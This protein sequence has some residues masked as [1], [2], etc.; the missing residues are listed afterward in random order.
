MK[1]TIH[2]ITFRDALKSACEVAPSKG[3]LP[4]QSCLYLRVQDD[5][6][7][8]CARDEST[9]IELVIPCQA[10][11]DGE[12]LVPSR[13]LLDYVSLADGSVTVSVDA[14]QRM[15]LKSGKKTSALACMDTDRFKP[16]AF[17]GEPVFTIDGAALSACIS[18]T[19]FA[20][21]TDE[22]RAVLCGIHLTIDPN[23]SAHFASCNGVEIAQC[24]MDKLDFNADWSEPRGIT[25]PNTALKLIQS[26]FGSYDHVTLSLETYRAAF[27]AEGKR[28]A[29]PLISKEFPDIT[30]VYPPSYKTDIR[31]LARPFLEALRLVEIA[32]SSAPSKD[33][34]WNLIRLQTD[35]E[36]GCLYLSADTEATEAR[37]AVDCDVQ[38]EDM[39]IF[40]NVRYLK[41]LTAVCGKESD[42]LSFSLSSPVGVARMRPLDCPAVM[43]AYVVPVRTSHN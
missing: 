33:N 43:S 14:K 34:R 11:E 29:F 7:T 41:D 25:L 13:M 36:N 2:S 37:T 15:T 23:G 30:R 39:T 24:D 4:E 35:G 38:G 10:Q 18:R 20:C 12:A 1:F 9:D 6:L 21:S 22:T 26:Q 27:S 28:M 40:F 42:E 32:A 3:I 8:I 19:S 5:T 31:I 17:A 16:M